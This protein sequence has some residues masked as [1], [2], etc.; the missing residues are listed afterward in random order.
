MTILQT[1]LG[2]NIERD[3]Q[4]SVFDAY[5]KLE[6]MKKAAQDGTQASF[7]LPEASIVGLYGLLLRDEQVKFSDLP[8][9]TLGFLLAAFTQ[10]V[11]D[12]LTDADKEVVFS[13]IDRLGTPEKAHL[14]LGNSYLSQAAW[15]KLGVTIDEATQAV[16]ALSAELV[17]ELVRLK[18]D[19]QAP[20]LVLDLGKSIKE[21]EAL[22]KAKGITVLKADGDDE[23][24]RAEACYRAAGP[25]TPR[26]LLLPG[27][28][29]GVLPGSRGK[30]YDG[31][32]KYME[33]NY[34]GYEVGGAR[35]LVTL[36][37]MKYL[38]DG[39]VLFPKEPCTLGRCKERYQTG[40]W[41]DSIVVLGGRSSSASGG[42]VVGDGLGSAYF[43]NGRFGVLGVVS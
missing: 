34:P 24:L 35:E 18:K 39:T 11:L 38:Q 27:S 10:E 4:H 40:G 1:E 15:E 2:K 32:K 21:I 33:Q 16:P 3:A 43:I 23:K 31:Q 28:D 13:V 8:E 12:S 26:W 5:K 14:L 19:G 20:I 36:A 17:T 6:A 25:A 30:H 22:C 7:S 9:S 42:L 41:K 29:H 37:M